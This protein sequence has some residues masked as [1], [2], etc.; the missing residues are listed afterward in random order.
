VNSFLHPD[1]FLVIEADPLA[2]THQIRNWDQLEWYAHWADP[3]P[4]AA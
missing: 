2:G 1:A 3:Y 4:E